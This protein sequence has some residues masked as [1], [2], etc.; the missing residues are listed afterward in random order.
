[1][2]L[3]RIV[4]PVD[5]RRGEDVGRRALLDL[6]RECGTRG[7]ARRDFDAGRLVNSASTSSS[8]FL[9]DAA[10]NTVSVSCARAEEE[11]RIP[12]A[13][14]AIA[15]RRATHPPLVIARLDRA[16]QQSPAVIVLARSAI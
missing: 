5:I 8:A 4:H 6:L 12:R 2:L 9:S 14:H 3:L 16:I 13:T 15:R 10:A 11:K 1:L 7:V